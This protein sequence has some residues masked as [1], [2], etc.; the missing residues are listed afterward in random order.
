MRKKLVL[1][2][3]KIPTGLAAADF[4][5]SSLQCGERRTQ[6]EISK[7]A[8]ITEVTVRNRYKELMKVLNFNSQN[9]LNC[10]YPFNDLRSFFVKNSIDRN[11]DI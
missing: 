1:L 6:R 2:R 11:K 3:V 5:Y 8:N 10:L 9:G 7:I 4:I